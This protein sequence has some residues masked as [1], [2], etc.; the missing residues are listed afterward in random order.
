MKQKTSLMLCSV[1]D[2]VTRR[3]GQIDGYQNN[4]YRIRFPNGED[5]LRH[6]DQ[7][8]IMA[9]HIPPGDL[10]EVATMSDPKNGGPY[11]HLGHGTYRWVLQPHAHD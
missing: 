5:V 8:A 4:V 6:L 10:P 3:T 7:F 9:H 2:S 1:I 11:A